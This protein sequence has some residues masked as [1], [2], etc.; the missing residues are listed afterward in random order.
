[1]YQQ[2]ALWVA[3]FA[4]LF[5]SCGFIPQK[6]SWDDSR[7]IPLLKAIEAVDRSSLGFTPIDRSSTVRLESRP[8]AGYD[9]MLH[10][11]G[12]T[13][14]TIAFRKTPDGYKWIHEQETYTGPKTYKN[15]DG[16]FHEQ[17]V[18]TYGIEPVSG[19]AANK[20][21]VEY[22]GEDPRLPAH[23]PLTLEQVRPIIAEWNK[24]K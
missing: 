9:A 18:I 12:K 2:R 10:I 24:T 14:R 23:Q 20:L 8:R 11:D 13:S 7:L 3:T 16:T 17:I 19:H 4:L 22:W 21:H 15:V 5:A 1:M 6:V